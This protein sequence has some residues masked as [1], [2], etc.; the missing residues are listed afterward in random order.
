MK[1]K[2]MIRTLLQLPALLMAVAL[3]GTGCE[4][5]FEW[6]VP[7]AVT[8]NGLDLT[9]AAGSTRITVYATGRWKAELT[10]G[11]WAEVSEVSGNG[12]GD[13]L[14]TYRANNG[15]SRRARIVISGEGHEEEIVLKQAGAVTEPTL[16]LAQSE[17]EFVR[18]PREHCSIGVK[19]NM[20]QALEIITIAVK[21][22]TDG[23]H[24]AEAE[25]LTDVRLEKDAEENV[26][27]LFGIARNDSGSDRK[28]SILLEIPD[29]DGKVLATAEASIVQTVDDASVVFTDAGTV[30]P[31]PGDQHNRSALLTANFDV[32]PAR[33][34]YEVSY[35]PA[36]EQWISAVT[37][38]PSAV[39]FAVAE[40][41]GEQPRSAALKITYRDDDVTC[42]ST[43][44]L[45][46]EVKQFSIA[47]LRALIPAAEGSLLLTS[48][49]LLSAIVISDAGNY[50]MEVNPNLTD[51]S[52]DF[53]VNE[54]TAYI[55]SLDGQYG[56]R[57][58][59]RLPADNI[60]K[61]YSS[62]QLSIKGLTLV[63]ESAP[64]RYTLTGFTQDH[65]VNQNAG[66]AA[67]LPKKE[68]F[69]SELTDADLYT[70]VTLRECEFMLN[71][72]AYI[73]V[74]DGYCLR[75][76][77]NTMGV[78][79]P[80]FDCGM[81]GVIDSRGSKINMLLNTQVRWRR[82]GDGVPAGSGPMSGIIVHSKLPRYGVKGDVGTY[83]IRPVEEADIAFAKEESTRNYSTLV[84]WAW[85]GMT[86]NAGIKQHEDGS[87]VPYQGEG[88]MFSSVSNKI[89]SSAAVAGIAC[90]LD[91]NNLNYA[92][93]ITA[94]ALRYN[95]IWWNTSRNEGEY[96]AFSFSTEGVNGSCMKMILST[97]LG[98]LS[99][100]TIVAPLYWDVSYSLDGGANYTRF[101][102]VPI[103][104][105]AY[106]AG[107][108]WYVPGLGEVEIDLPAA[109][110][111]QREVTVKLQAA[112]T[113][114]GTATGEDNG[115]TTQTYV[116]FRFGDVSVKYF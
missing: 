99:A 92:K 94:P 62:L 3:L 31:V 95:G 100:A 66:T 48:E 42:S 104:S 10:E 108:Q 51:T 18:L 79:D 89:N 93:G 60:L 61:R 116:Y 98:G 91:Y 26:Q 103:R 50:N 20:T 41:T 8:Q 14:F 52:I 57:I 109:C 36:G 78:N 33:F 28:A 32:D 15:V 84:R 34:S 5:D 7:L 102:T 77:L 86:T 35:D 49:K 115:T 30:V 72:G 43:L 64:E 83:Q 21:D 65:V 73:N 17:L 25:W 88:R 19:T 2:N 106:W 29:A 9:A 70:Y 4:K 76:D 112:S 23:E 54:K 110:F 55:E 113:T 53:S 75:T 67:D 82:K 90:T 22:I 38:T 16:T 101:D 74:H 44:D 47:D 59:T 40:N 81:R 69:I 45:T 107:P 87:I 71:G 97:V 114:C 1:P 96:V 111:G 24:P 37:F 13:F 105:I 46:Q 39:S 6:N 56:L 68:K 85:P 11:S 80:R 27:L 12:I 63:K 58:V